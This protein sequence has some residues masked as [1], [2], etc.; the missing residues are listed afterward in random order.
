MVLSNFCDGCNF[1]DSTQ[2]KGYFMTSAIYTN[3]TA[4]SSN[5]DF[6]WTQEGSPGLF[7][8]I[9][10]YIQSPHI[11]GLPCSARLAILLYLIIQIR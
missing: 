6:F 5:Y 2:W 1:R 4:T 8:S 10:E 7:N 11:P 9:W 3:K